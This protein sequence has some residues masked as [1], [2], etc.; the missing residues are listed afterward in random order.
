MCMFPANKLHCVGTWKDQAN[1]FLKV[2]YATEARVGA[3][4][5]SLDS[6]LCAL[7]KFYVLTENDYSNGEHLWYQCTCPRFRKRAKC[8]HV[9]AYAVS[10]GHFTVPQQKSL[11][12]IG[13]KPRRGRP[14][15]VR[16]THPWR[17]FDSDNE[18]TDDDE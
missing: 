15:K 8:K 16:G 2:V 3:W 13:R 9:L 7:K 14:K 10:Q 4:N 17:R 6:L 11:R 12:T 5:Y 1:C 18:A